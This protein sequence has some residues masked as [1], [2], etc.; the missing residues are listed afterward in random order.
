MIVEDE[1]LDERVAQAHDGG[2]LV[3]D[4]DMRRVE[5]LADVS[6]RHVP[7]L[8]AARRFPRPPAPRRL[9]RCNSSTP[10]GPPGVIG[11]TFSP[12]RE[13]IPITSPPTDPKS[14]RRKSHRISPLGKA[15]GSGPGRR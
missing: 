15:V 12:R 1:L 10:E 3:L 8:G 11:H 9:C 13:P 5:R 2:A 6:N 14:P 4:L 7:R